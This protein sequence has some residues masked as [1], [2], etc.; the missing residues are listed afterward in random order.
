MA[1]YVTVTVTGKV[2]EIGELVQK[3]LESA[4]TGFRLD[5]VV[6]LERTPGI[7]PTI[8]LLLILVR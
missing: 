2:M 3:G 5:R 4:P 8:T 1:Q 7:S 6:E